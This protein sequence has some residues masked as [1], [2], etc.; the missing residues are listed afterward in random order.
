MHVLSTPLAQHK[1]IPIMCSIRF[2]CSV[3]IAG[4][5]SI[6]LI[7]WAPAPYVVSGSRYG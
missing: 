7:S 4:D 6:V 5:V 3:D 1:N 2:T